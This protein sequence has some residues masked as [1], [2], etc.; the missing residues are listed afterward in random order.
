MIIA[1]SIISFCTT[2]TISNFIP[3]GVAVISSHYGMIPSEV[4]IVNDRKEIDV[5]NVLDNPE[6]TFEISRADATRLGIPSAS[7][8]HWVCVGNSHI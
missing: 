7:N 4:K 2:A 6:R 5:L 3:Q 8:S 1:A